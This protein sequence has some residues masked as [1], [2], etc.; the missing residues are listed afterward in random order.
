MNGYCSEG[1]GVI[2][3]NMLTPGYT[4]IRILA[5]TL[6]YRKEHIP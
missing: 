4:D 3:K 2:S 5:L 1:H 6:G